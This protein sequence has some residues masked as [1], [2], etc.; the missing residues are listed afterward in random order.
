VKFLITGN[1]KILAPSLG[2]VLIEKNHQVVFSGFSYQEKYIPGDDFQFVPFEKEAEIQLQFFDAYSFDSLIYITAQEGWEFSPANKWSPQGTVDLE[3]VLSLSLQT[4]IK[5]II[6]ISSVLVYG[7]AID[8][9]ENANPSPSS[10]YGQL[11]SNEE[12]ICKYFTETYPLEVDIIR[13]PN[14]YGPMEH[15][16]FLNQL[17]AKAKA[18]NSIELHV[19]EM[20]PCHFLHVED[21][22][23]FISLKLDEEPTSGL[24][25][26]NLSAEDINYSFLQQLVGYVV[27]GAEITF[28]E[29]EAYTSFADSIQTEQAQNKYAWKPRHQ[30]IQ[31]IQLLAADNVGPVEQRRSGNIFQSFK[32]VVRPFLVWFEVILGAFLMHLL[33]I[34]TDTLIEFKY[35]DYRLF[36]VV[37][38]GSTHGLFFGILSALLACL[39]ILVKWYEI[40][41]DWALIAYNVENWIP[42]ALLFLA[43]SVTGYQHDKKEN[44]IIFEKHQTALIHEKYEFLYKLYDEISTIKNQLRDQLV[45]Y[46]DSFG[47][48]FKVTNELNELDA[49]Q[50][51]IKAIEVLEDLMQNDQI[52]IYS[53]EPMGNFGRL[54]VKSKSIRAEIPKSINLNADYS[55][56]IQSVRAGEIFQNKGLLPNYP[57]Y[58]APIFENETL[59]GLVSLWEASFEQF[60]MYYLN[61]FRITTGLVQSA[62]VRAAT[63]Q[64]MQ[65]EK[66]YLPATSILRPDAFRKAI[67]IKKTMRRKKIADYLVLKIKKGDQDW[68]KLYE[69]LSKGVRN[70]D[71]IG[72]LDEN[73][74]ECYALLS[75]AE[76]QHLD[77]IQQRLEKLGLKSEYVTEIIEG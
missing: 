41:L 14:V 67:K 20:A 32:S 49:D 74:S 18:E 70:E 25:I 65:R 11:L 52:A 13:L 55:D 39:S 68:E 76:I 66:Q 33:T 5:R 47:R 45:G 30:L 46:R 60:S 56:A 69:R 21:F 42:F 43:G 3:K 71:V 54:E 29:A 36:Y 51:F 57:A 73:D 7:D 38:I 17:I 31:E 2:R 6:L 37:L 62:L 9:S 64:I 44:E 12:K 75:H 53:V 19:P 28:T 40:G 59:I 26:F 27:P 10:L 22:L 35:I 4:G 34:W 48:F 50:I 77:M 8:T 23:D 24:Q 1:L 58:M 15:N 61:L 16:S 63:F 72:V